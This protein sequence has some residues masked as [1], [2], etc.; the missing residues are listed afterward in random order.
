MPDLSPIEVLKELA[1][2][3]PTYISFWEGGLLAPNG[4]ISSY[5]VKIDIYRHHTFVFSGG[6]SSEIEERAAKIVFAALEKKPLPQ[7]SMHP[8]FS[9]NEIIPKNFSSNS[10]ELQQRFSLLEA[11]GY[12]V[13]LLNEVRPNGVNGDL[14][15][16]YRIRVYGLCDVTGESESNLED[17]YSIAGDKF[18]AIFSA[19]SQ[20]QA[21][22]P[23][24]R[25]NDVTV[26][27]S[28]SSQ[29]V[30]EMIGFE[31]SSPTPMSTPETRLS[32]RFLP[33]TKK[34]ECDLQLTECDYLWIGLINSFN[35]GNS[36]VYT[37][38]FNFKIK[39]KLVYFNSLQGR[40]FSCG[41]HPRAD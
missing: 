10:A 25:T 14:L 26:T 34:D 32:K 40:A 37:M 3:L 38:N 20:H 17:A 41:C 18:K 31:S 39:L 21:L 4:T 16:V 15:F 13:Q 24:I 30:L 9:S 29:S 2:I 6:S 23:N 22:E 36:R 7:Q 33:F 8:P 27:Q 1:T 12:R 19:N 11:N 35:K 5:T 28:H